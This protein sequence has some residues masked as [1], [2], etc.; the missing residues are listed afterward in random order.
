MNYTSKKCQLGM[1]IFNSY[2]TTGFFYTSAAR[3]F[4]LPPFTS[5]K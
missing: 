2:V 4:Y 1:F 5:L 3:M